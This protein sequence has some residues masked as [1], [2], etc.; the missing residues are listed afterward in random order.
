MNQSIENLSQSKMREGE[1][2]QA[3]TPSAA[4]FHLLTC[5]SFSFLSLFRSSSSVE[6]KPKSILQEKLF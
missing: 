2:N 5:A 1:V 4:L 3:M 6:N